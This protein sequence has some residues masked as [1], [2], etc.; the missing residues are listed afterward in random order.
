MQGAYVVENGNNFDRAIS[1][2]LGYTD[3]KLNKTK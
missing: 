2:S 1:E 3:A